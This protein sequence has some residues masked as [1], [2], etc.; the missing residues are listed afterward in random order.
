MCRGS[1]TVAGMV[2]RKSHT[3][4]RALG[5]SSFPRRMRSNEIYRWCFMRGSSRSGLNI[6]FG[7]NIIWRV[8][9]PAGG[10]HNCH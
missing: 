9:A 6:I 5:A 8:V 10:Y 1:R 4:A 3:V 2:C 7:L